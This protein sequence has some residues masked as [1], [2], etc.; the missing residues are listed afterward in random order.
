MEKRVHVREILKG[1][2]EEKYLH[3]LQLQC[4]QF[5]YIKGK[6]LKIHV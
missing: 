5:M 1:G 6:I 4:I 2:K 3:I